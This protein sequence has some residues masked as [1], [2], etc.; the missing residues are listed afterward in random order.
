MINVNG[1]DVLGVGGFIRSK[2]NIDFSRI[3]IELYSQTPS[4]SHRK[5]E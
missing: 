1:Q 4:G 3:Q 2:K 5:V